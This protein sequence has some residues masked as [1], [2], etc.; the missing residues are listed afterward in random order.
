M[1]NAVRIG[2]GHTAAG[3][4]HGKIIARVFAGYSPMEAARTEGCGIAGG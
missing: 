3:T 2:E 1:E 4:G